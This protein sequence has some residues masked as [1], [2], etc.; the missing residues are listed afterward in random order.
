[1]FERYDSHSNPHRNKLD[2]LR[3][4]PSRRGNLGLVSVCLTL[5]L[6]NKFKDFSYMFLIP[7]TRNIR[8]CYFAI[9]TCYFR[10]VLLRSYAS[11]L[12]RNKMHTPPLRHL[13]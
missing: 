6:L 2:L 12:C 5:L 9:E 8:L 7:F 13:K 10:V 1:M 4:K 11:N 3:R